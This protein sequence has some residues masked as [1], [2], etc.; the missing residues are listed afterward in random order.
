VE[1]AWHR[2]PLDAVI[3]FFPAEWLPQLPSI[4][5]RP[6][7]TPGPALHV[8]PATALIVQSKR[9]PLTW[10]ALHTPL[11]TW[12]RL[13]PETVDPRRARV[14][15]GTWVLKSALGRVGDGVAVPGVTSARDW[16]RMRWAARLRPRAWVA[17]RRFESLARETDDG[18]LHVCV[19]VFVVDGRAAG[20]YARASR[21]ALIDG[22]AMDVPVLVEDAA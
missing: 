4:R 20:A 12:R 22:S 11:P 16:S 21:K 9:F 7:L 3:R 8:N 2:G 6:Y 10:N 13:L 17:Q 5:W 14:E 19:G 15:D 1:T 18:A